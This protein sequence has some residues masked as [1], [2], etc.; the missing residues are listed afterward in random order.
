MTSDIST[1][2][3]ECGA[4]MVISHYPRLSLGVTMRFVLPGLIVLLLSTPTLPS[5]A[6]GFRAYAGDSH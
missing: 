4:I 2:T 1:K 5:Y 6:Q 3:H